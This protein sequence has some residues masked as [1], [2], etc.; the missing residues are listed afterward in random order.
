VFLVIVVLYAVRQ[1]RLQKYWQLMVA[2]CLFAGY[3][4]PPPISQGIMV[5]VNV[6]H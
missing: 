4:I 5:A 3:V 1:R 6:E 2:G